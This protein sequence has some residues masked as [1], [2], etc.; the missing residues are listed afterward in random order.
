MKGGK[1]EKLEDL[2]KDMNKE[3]LKGQILG[4]FT[5]LLGA[6]KDLL[7]PIFLWSLAQCLKAR[8]LDDNCLTLSKYTIG[9]V[10]I[11]F[12]FM[13][14]SLFPVLVFVGCIMIPLGILAFICAIGQ[15][16][17]TFLILI[18]TR[19]VIEEKYC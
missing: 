5:F 10:L 4:I 8:G 17:W 14:M 18:N 3:I 7:V 11:G 13:G 2:K 19:R 6:V 16:I 1:L 9:S 15:I 12:I